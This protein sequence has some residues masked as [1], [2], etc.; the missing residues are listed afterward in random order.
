MTEEARERK[1]EYKIPV[2]ELF[3]PTIQGE[4]LLLGHP[5]FF[6]RT[7]GCGYK[8]TWCDSMHAVDPAQVK[9]NRTMMTPEQITSRLHREMTTPWLTLTG[10]DP[11]LHNFEEIV[12]RLHSWGRNVC[13]ETQG[14]LWPDWLKLVDVVTLSPKGPSSGNITEPQ[15][16]L[17]NLVKL[18]QRSRAKIAVKI[19]VFTE[20]D[21]G[22]AYEM[23]NISPHLFPLIN[24][25]YFQ[26]GT[27][28]TEQVKEELLYQY[29]GAGAAPPESEND[30]NSEARGVMRLTILER[31]NWL[32]QEVLK[33][34]DLHPKVAV[35][36]QMHAL[37]WPTEDRGR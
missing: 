37:L 21:L 3:G 1:K 31:Y 4:G 5:T 17:A 11:C 6:L 30:L 25:F 35:T 33:M 13:V 14:E 2:I 20:A 32:T 26:V 23:M 27:P 29:E 7:G 28:L 16:F 15:E 19:V 10:G 9:A 36:P 8:C 22:Y 24:G 34:G 12:D 18:S